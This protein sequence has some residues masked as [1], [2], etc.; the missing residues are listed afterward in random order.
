MA[1]LTGIRVLDLTQLIAG[2]AAGLMLGQLGADVV[3][4]ESDT[5]DLGRALGAT[6]GNSGTSATFRVYNRRKRFVSLDLKSEAGRSEME[7]LVRSADVLLEN[8]RPGVMERLGLGYH[9]LRESNPRLIYCSLTGFPRTSADAD[10]GG[11]DIIIQAESGIMQTTGFPDGPPVKVG[12][13]M[14]DAATSHVMM[15]AVLAAI[16]ERQHSG[17]GTKIDVSLYE[18]ALHLQ[19]SPIAQY[20]ATGTPPQRFGNS[21]IMSAPADTFPT[22]DG[23]LV[24]STYTPKHW[25]ALC[26]N[27]GRADL[28]T[29]ARYA[30][31]SARVVHRDEL[32]ATLAETFQHETAEHWTKLLSPLGLPVG[33]VRSLADVVD[34]E[35]ER[36]NGMISG[37]AG[38]ESV[39]LPYVATPDVTKSGPAPETTFALGADQHAVLGSDATT[40][41]QT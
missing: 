13:T 6:T 41:G 33:R 15:H 3:K 40:G 37:E 2:P 31:V 1:A 27:I 17:A 20:V 22:A 19:A 36:P 28:L 18:V 32:W 16:L 10:R 21:A 38:S 12:F 30:D 8:F 34:E 39:R 23:E 35:R 24:V 26:E 5:G 25:R 4:I 14:V 29:D 7:E 9:A 11:V